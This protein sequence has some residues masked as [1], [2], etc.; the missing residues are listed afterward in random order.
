M[1]NSRLNDMTDKESQSFVKSRVPENTEAI[2]E[3]LVAMNF[4]EVT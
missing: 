2:V 4:R 3:G 1:K